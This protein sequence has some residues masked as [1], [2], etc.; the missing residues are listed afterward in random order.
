MNPWRKGPKDMSDIF[1]KGQKATIISVLLTLLLAFIKAFVGVI[2]GSIVLIG[3][4]FHSAADSLSSLGAW[5]GLRVA[6]RKPT[7]KFS[8]GYYKAENLAAL[9]ISGLIFLAGFLIAKESFEKIF[10]TYQI[11]LP[12][13]AILAALVD[14]IVMFL[15]GTYEMKVGK[16]INSQSLVADGKESRMHLLSSFIVL[17]GIV[18][19]WLKI[20]YIE[21]L[22][23]FVISLF[24]FHTGFGSAKDAL[25]SL[26]DVSVSP[27]KE[28]KIKEILASISGIRGF[29]NLKLRKSGPF[30]F[31]EVQIKIGKNLNA[32][33]ISEIS[34]SIEKKIRDNIKEIDSFV[35]TPVPY[36]TKIQKIALP[37]EEDKGLESKISF[38]FGRANKFIFIQ[39]EEG[40]IKNFYTK[41]NPFKENSSKA[42][43][44]TALFLIKEKID[45]VITKEIGNISLYALRDNIV[46]IYLAKNDNIK[47]LIKNLSEEKLLLA[48][49]PTKEK[50]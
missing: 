29:N 13:I 32:K 27:E 38:Q 48:Q 9:L 37:I 12:L 31:G 28:T 21:S 3:D 19:A 18:S 46:D 7:Q 6:K 43:L 2:S 47:D 49:E 16:E 25:F 8:Y 11:K 20:P 39:I 26:M 4:S 5:V 34:Q 15:I 30:V 23:G 45:S 1:Q 17:V 50:L 41:A 40:K 10:T 36:Q 22:M 44:N 14:A 35:I 33:R 42:G 24:I